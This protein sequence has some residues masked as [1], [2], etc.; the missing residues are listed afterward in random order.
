MSFA[1]EPDHLD[2]FATELT[3]L[4]DADIKSAVAYVDQH[5]TIE[6]ADVGLFTEAAGAVRDANQAIGI[7]LR[8]VGRLCDFSASELRAVAQIYRSVDAT[9]RARIDATYPTGRTG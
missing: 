9:E 2:A 7:C 5:L 6:P 3:R 8:R 4:H 1:V